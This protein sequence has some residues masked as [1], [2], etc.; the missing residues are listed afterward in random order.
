MGALA[1]GEADQ[2]LSDQI[3]AQRGETMGK[4]AWRSRSLDRVTKW[5]GVACPLMAY[6]GQGGRLGAAHGQT[7]RVEMLTDWWA[8]KSGYGGGRSWRGQGAS[9]GQRGLKRGVL[10][11]KKSQW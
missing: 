1:L 5:R 3:I 2:Y 11:R 4:G 9:H 6:S 8:K 7:V 10:G